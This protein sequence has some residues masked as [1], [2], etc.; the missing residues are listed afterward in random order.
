MTTLK[1]Y[2]EAIEYKISE[3]S[4]YQWKCFGDNARYLD[5]HGPVLN[6][7]YSIHCIFDAVDQTVYTLEAWDYRTNREY[8][9]INP[10]YRKTFEK[11]CK[12]Q[13]VDVDESF[14]GQ[15]FID[16]ELAEDI[17][18]KI[19]ALVN[20]REYD[21]KIKIPLDIPDEELLQYMKLAHQMDITFNELMSRAVD[22]LAKDVYA[23]VLTKKEAK[24]FRK[25]IQ[26]ENS[27]S[28]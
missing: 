18:A 2:I 27:T 20:N 26:N 25:R 5:C 16:C 19:N 10:E 21:T 23:G 9:W 28:K 13:N 6:Q 4:E 24:K 12:K 8:R 14:D 17:L 1:D 7:D 3:G 22:G 11:E 15:S